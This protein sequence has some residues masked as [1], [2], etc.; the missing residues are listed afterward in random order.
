MPSKSNVYIKG[1]NRVSV[2][3]MVKVAGG[4]GA[5]IVRISDTPVVPETDIHGIQCVPPDIVKV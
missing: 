2:R 4:P 3:T 1:A 5:D